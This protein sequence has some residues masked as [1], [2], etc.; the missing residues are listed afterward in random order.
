MQN[1]MPSSY[2]VWKSINVP[3]E[4][5][6]PHNEYDTPGRVRRIP[7]TNAIR[8]QWGIMV[9]GLLL[10]VHCIVKTVLHVLIAHKT[11]CHSRQQ[12]HE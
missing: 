2:N 5:L 12:D 7:A 10:H 11:D 9:M 4:T 6:H 8:L 1:A 3:T